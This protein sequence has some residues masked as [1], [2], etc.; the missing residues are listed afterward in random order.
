[1]ERNLRAATIALLAVAVIA[2]GF[3]SC[4][5]VNGH[6][7]KGATA[8]ITFAAQPLSNQT[9]V[10][11][12]LRALR[13]HGR[14]RRP[15]ALPFTIDVPTRGGGGAVVTGV[16]ADG[17][18]VNISWYGGQPLTLEGTGGLDPGGADVGVS[19]Q[20]FTWQLDG[21]PRRLQ[22][23]QYRTTAAVAVGRAGLGQAQD[24]ATFDAGPAA[25]LV[26]HGGASI[27]LSPGD[28]HLDGPG[29]LTMDGAVT[30]Q[31]AAS[32]RPAA[33]VS[34]GPG[35]F[36]VDLTLQPDGTYLVDAVLQGPVT[37][38]SAHL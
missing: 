8:S 3:H 9:L 18:A 35:A 28:V 10:R 27:H 30:V 16:S 20:G 14:P 2:I 11:G 23:G 31:T 13:G 37:S 34:F 1:V 21:Q 4:S 22:P 38:S 25:A 6:G 17:H 33:S 24:G 15:F 5:T 12:R 29:L 36:S 19:G 32:I 7:G 26:S